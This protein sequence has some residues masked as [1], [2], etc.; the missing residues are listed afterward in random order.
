MMDRCAACGSDRWSIAERC[1]GY[2]LAT[3]RDCGLTFT[4]NPDYS[5]QRY[6]VA[7][8]QVPGEA[9]VPEKDAYKYSMPARRLE[10]ECMALIPPAPRLTPAQR[11]ALNWLKTKL[12]ARGTVLDYGCGSGSFLWAL[13]RAH[14]HAVGLEVADLLVH[15]L[16]RRGF[17]AIAASAADFHWSGNPPA[18]ITFF[19]VLEHFPDPQALIGALKQR[20]P[21]A[22]IL[23][24]VPSPLRSG[25]L[26]RG[27]RSSTDLPPN[28]YLRWT[29][30]ALELFF[31]RVGYNS[32]TVVLPAPVGSEMMPGAGQLL[33]RLTGSSRSAATDGANRLSSGAPPWIACLGA[34][35]MLWLQR[36]Y[37]TVMDVIGAPRAWSASCRGATAGSM[38]VIAE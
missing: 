18:A 31:R 11:L 26:L 29:P 1:A 36:T 7:Y 15:L 3:C 23:A 6:L 8:R 27:E 4:R 25:L 13:R 24:S 17:E 21:D 28:H 14:F 22:M 2:E 30:R 9:P 10:L 34:M 33:T 5:S 20:F 12:P 19:E 38:L 16:R 32:V 37:Q 35:A